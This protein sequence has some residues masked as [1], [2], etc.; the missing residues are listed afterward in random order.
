MRMMMPR[1]EQ[2][3][4]EAGQTRAQLSRTVEELHGRMTPGP[5]IDQLTNYAREGTAAEFRRN[6]EREVRENPLPLV[7]IGIG[8]AWLIVASSRSSR[9]PLQ[10]INEV[11]AEEGKAPIT[12]R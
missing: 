7:L 2:L 8:I 10:I 5:V 12:D 9:A 4:R 6:L 1:I 3:E 11:R